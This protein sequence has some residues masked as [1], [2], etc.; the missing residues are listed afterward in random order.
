MNKHRQHHES[1]PDVPKYLDLFN[2]LAHLGVVT[3]KR[4]TRAWNTCKS[5]FIMS[6]PPAGVQDEPPTDGILLRPTVISR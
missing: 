2:S 6:T 1:I 5:S 3:I 4:G